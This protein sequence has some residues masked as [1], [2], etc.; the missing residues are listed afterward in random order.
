MA[1][2]TEKK[3]KGKK[4]KS[5]DVEPA[6]VE[7][8]VEESTE[9]VAEETAELEAEV[10]EETVE[11]DAVEEEVDDTKDEP[12]EAPIKKAIGECKKCKCV[13]AGEVGEFDVVSESIGSVRIKTTDK[14][15]KVRI[16]K[17]RKLR[18]KVEML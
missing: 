1:N 2:E 12:V 15:G 18:D 8:T 11:E 5:K 3:K 13:L 16:V 9:E 7:E 14:G 17:R 4:A 10:D 6:P